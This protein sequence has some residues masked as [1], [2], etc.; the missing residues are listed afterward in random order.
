M[1]AG[2]RHPA[3]DCWK[4]HVK[5]LIGIPLASSCLKIENVGSAQNM[6]LSHGYPARKQL[7]SQ[8][9]MRV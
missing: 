7:A 9:I 5:A 2:S 3:Q 8:N 1:G 6:K 4:S